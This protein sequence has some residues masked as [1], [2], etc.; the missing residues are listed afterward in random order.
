M[1]KKDY[2]AIAEAI[3]V[4]VRE[5]IGIDGRRINILRPHEVADYLADIMEEDN[6]R[7][8]RKRFM[9]ACMAGIPQSP[10]WDD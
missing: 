7:F 3:R 8:D 6:E 10:A 2:V 5:V 4:N 1:T 9:E